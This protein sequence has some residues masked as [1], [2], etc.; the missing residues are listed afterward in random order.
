MPSFTTISFVIFLVLLLASCGGSEDTIAPAIPFAPLVDST[1]KD[2]DNPT[3]VFR[4]D[5]AEV[6]QR[7]P[8]SRAHLSALSPNNVKALAQEKLDQIYARITAGPLPGGAYRNEIFFAPDGSLRDRLAEIVGGFQGRLVGTAVDTLLL[9]VSTV[10]TGKLFYREQGVARTSIENLPPLQAI[11]GDTETIMTATI[12]RQGPLRFI[13]PDKKVWLLFPAK[14][15]CGQSL[16]DGRRESVIIDYNYGED[17]AGYRANPDSFAG[18]GGLRLRDEIRMVRPGFYL[19]RAYVGRVFLL[20]FTLYN[21]RLADGERAGF[22]SDQ[23]IAEDCWTG[24]QTS[25]S[26]ARRGADCYDFRTFQARKH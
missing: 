18:R 4:V 25:A 15:Y 12:P 22:L 21:E 20:N 8:L 2:P 26:A 5:F 23:P 17:I 24:E 9:V 7:Y 1:I 13:I 14:F 11:L 19:G 3:K 6:Q 10:W 16:L